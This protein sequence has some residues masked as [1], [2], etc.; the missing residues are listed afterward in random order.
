[1]ATSNHERVGRALELLRDGLRPFVERELQA[2]YGAGWRA[3]VLTGMRLERPGDA[4]SAT[5]D[6]YILLALMWDLWNDVFRDVL[7]QAERSLV[8]ELRE[9][10]N[11]WA[12][13]N[14][15]TTEDAYRMLDDTG[16]LL[17]AI[18]ADQ[19]R[20]VERERQ[21]LLRMQVD[22]QT[23][24]E[25][26]QAATA[27]IEGKPQGGLRP[28]RE[29][30]MPHPDV[31]S[32][33]YQQAEFA[34]DLA[35]VYRGEGTSEYADPTEFYRRTFLTEGLRTLLANALR[36]LA[37]NGG[38]PVVELQTN[39]G[40]G[41]THSMLALYHLCAGREAAELPGIESLLTEAKVDGVPRGVRRAVLV[42]TALS[43][44]QPRR[45]PDGVETRTLWG[46]MAWQLGGKDGY[47][48]VAEADAAGVSPGSDALRDL[49]V[50][51]EPCLILIDEWVAFARMLY[52]V[53]GL[54]AGSFDANLTFAQSL[55]EAARQSPRTLLVASIPSSDIEI[56]GEAG[57]LALE[58]LKNTFS[59]VESAWRPASAE[60]GYEIVRRRLFQPMSDPASFTARDTVAKA[61]SQYYRDN[62]GEFPLDCR[63]AAYE[64]RIRDAYPIHPELFD[65]LYKD[66]SSLDKFQRTRGVL[67]LMA[68]VI[69]TLWERQDGG[70]LIMPAA[71]PIDAPSVQAELTRYLEDPWVPVIERDVDGPNSLPLATDRENPSLGRYSAARRVARTLYLGSAP[72]LNTAHRGLEDRD[73]KLG[74]AQPGEVVATFGDALRRLT[75]SATH[76]YVDG[77]RYW[78]STQP[79]VT[80]LAQDRAG[81]QDQADVQEE[82]KRRLRSEQGS[83]GDFVRVH[84][85]PSSSGDVTD[86][87]ESRLVMLGPEHTHSAKATDSP[88]LRTAGTILEQRGQS[89]R[90]YRNTV[91][92]LAA[93]KSRLE[94]LDQA[95]RQFLAW[96]SIDE[97]RESLNLDAFQANQART[98]RSQADDTV[99]QRVPEA[100]CWL[101]APRQP[102]PQAKDVEWQELRLQGA[103]SLA[104]RASKRLRND[105][106][107]VTQLGATVLRLELDRIPLWRGDHVGVKQILEDYA[108][109]LYLPRVKDDS[110]LLEAVKAG[111]ATLTWETEAFA[112]AEDW[113]EV[114]L[115]YRGL[116]CGSTG[117]VVADGRSVIVSPK[118]A[119]RQLDADARPRDLGGD[120]GTS[121]GTKVAETGGTTGVIG[122]YSVAQ[123]STQG[124]DDTETIEQVKPA[125]PRRFH[126][127]VKL[128]PQR[129][130]DNAARVNDAVIQHLVALLSARCEI[131]IEISA[132]VDDGVPENIVRT[133]SENCHTLKFTD[134]GFE[135]E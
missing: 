30:V 88:A 135:Q 92:F 55:T 87:R 10:R 83:R 40:G 8:S 25:L 38:D 124:T 123:T 15:F 103:D 102:D 79:T 51:F 6:V 65:R 41:K 49:F 3:Q 128:D 105:G 75:D 44:A 34:A 110:V 62:A 76:L 50:Y 109:Y 66:W 47:A 115:R 121:K 17:T 125:R 7:G 95:V 86:E 117:S 31:A 35:Q 24:R 97:E 133:V 37:G 80:R 69:H 82:I 9:F 2:R 61:Y 119:R 20:E 132:N 59:R 29:V 114:G 122:G 64:R 43:P 53:R 39:F 126:G 77:R 42:G 108:R 129:V 70:L 134:Y 33:R 112:Y 89:P 131:T 94:E 120:S 72:T 96:K 113:D 58:R 111:T 46:E 48:L 67:R 63:D 98:K 5:L 78:F 32:G 116:R 71:V 99:N 22:D 19:A 11:R 23:R 101:L 45:K 130:S 56:G 18:A 104:V 36:R 100:Y 84:V 107:L 74:C 4:A 85:S 90:L 16:R 21:A 60:E 27:T 106:L 12:H 73:V 118:A 1:M 93:D 13:Q 81:Q 52:G 28:W 127:S 91:V 26:K 68:A 14:A 54:P 57:K